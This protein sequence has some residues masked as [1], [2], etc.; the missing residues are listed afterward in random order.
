MKVTIIDTG[1]GNLL[2]LINAFNYNNAEVVITDSFAEIEKA[3]RLVLPGVG[4]FGDG[5]KTV[6]KM[7]EPIKN[8]LNKERPLLGICLG[9]Q[10]MCE[11]SHEFGLHKGL[12]LIEASVDPVPPVGEDGSSHKIP[13]I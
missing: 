1:S 5:M 12:G 7:L 8:Y 4:A 13:H 3:D 2:S 11:E 10:M 9:A 6:G